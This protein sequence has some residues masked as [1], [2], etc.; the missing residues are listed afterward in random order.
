MAFRPSQAGTSLLPFEKTIQWE[1]LTG[2]Q[3][4]HRSAVMAQQKRKRNEEVSSG[5][6]RPMQM[7]ECLK[8]FLDEGVVVASPIPRKCNTNSKHQKTRT[9]GVLQ[10]TVSIRAP[11]QPRLGE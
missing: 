11:A 1:K 7:T 2:Q 6:F 3:T 8:I 9:T 10:P 5:K 4:N